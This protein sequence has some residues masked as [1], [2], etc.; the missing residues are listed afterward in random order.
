MAA[1]AAAQSGHF[2]KI[3]IDTADDYTTPTLVEIGE[4][5]DGQWSLTPLSEDV[6]LKKH[7]GIQRSI[8]Y[9]ASI[10]ASF[11][12]KALP[13][14]YLTSRAYYVKLRNAA[15]SGT[16]VHLQMSDGDI[17]TAGKE[18]LKGW[19]TV[20]FSKTSPSGGTVDIAVSLSPADSPDDEIPAWGTVSA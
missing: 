6:M 15:L 12:V 8:P 2:E 9:G 19:W 4:A 7:K 13:T 18:Y 5:E 11:N 10:A 1:P 20:T 3:Y 16:P 14:D 17:T